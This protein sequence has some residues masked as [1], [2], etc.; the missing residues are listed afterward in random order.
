MTDQAPPTSDPLPPALDALCS[1]F[2]AA[3]QAGQRPRIEDCLAEA[4]PEHHPRLVRDLLAIEL[5]FRIRSGDRPTAE[6]LHARFPAFAAAVAAALSDAESVKTVGTDMHRRLTGPQELPQQLGRYRV[7]DQLGQGSFGIVYRARDDQLHRD[8]AI[9]VAHPERIT[10]EE[11]A[12]RYLVE[13]QNLA[14]LDHPG[15]VPVHD[16]G[17]TDDGR[18]FVVSKL[19]AGKDLAQRLRQGRPTVAESVE[20]VASVAEALHHAHRK[21]LV[22]RDI[23]PANI[24]LGADGHPVVADFGLALREA[25]FGTGPGFAGTPVYMSPEQARREGHRVDAR[26]DVYS[27]GVVFYEMLTGRRPFESNNRTEL[28]RLITM[29][30]PRPPRQHDDRI[31]QELDRICLKALSK[32]A[33]DR[34]STA[35]DLADDLRHWLRPL[36]AGGNLAVGGPRPAEQPHQLAPVA[37]PGLSKHVFISY[38]SPDQGAAHRLCQLLE[39]QGIGCWIAPRDV[40]PGADYGEAII[41]AIEE[42][43]ATVLL[44]SAHAN[45]SIHVTHEVERAT[46][47]RK[48]VVPVRLEDVRPSPSLELHL[49]SVQWVDAWRSAPHEVAAQLAAV[50]GG[51]GVARAIAPAAT[52]PL[53]PPGH[54]QRPVKIVPKGLRSF[55][56][57]DADFFLELVPGPRDRDGLPEGLRFW[58]GRIERMEADNTFAVGLMYGPS[59]CGKSSLVKAGLLPRLAKSVTAVYVEAT[60]EDTEARLFKGLRRQ[61]AELPCNLSLIESLAALRQGRFLKPG[62]KV[63]LVLDQFEQFLHARRNEENTELVQAL[64]Q[65]DGSRLQAIVLVRDDFWLAVSRFMQA[66]EIVPDGEN[67][68]LVDL[69]DPRHAKKVLIAFGQSFGALPEKDLAKDQAAFLDQAVAGLAQDGKVISVRLGLFAEMV[70]GKHWTPATLRKVGGTEGVGVSFLEETFTA[71]T[72]PPQHRLHQKAAQAV[73]KALLPEAGSDIKGHMR[74]Q[75]ELLMASGYVSRPKDFDDLLRILDS[76]VRLIT[77]TDPEG[78]DDADTSTLPA[79]GKYY[80]LT[81]D[82][83]V[84]SLR[85][86]LTRK[87]CETRRGRAELLLAERAAVWNAR[88]ENRQLPSLL[89]WLQIRALTGKKNWTPSERRMM[90]RAA[91]HHALR[92][93]AVFLVLGIIA[94]GSW[95]TYGTIQAQQFVN[96]LTNAKIAN[97]P[98]L[99]RSLGPYRRWADPLLLEQ[100]YW[101]PETDERLRISL[102]LLPIDPTQ[103]G[104]LQERL[105][106]A[107]EPEE[108]GAIR[109]L[110]HVYS[111]GSAEHFWAT[112]KSRQAKKGQRLRAAAAL[113]YLAPDDGQWPKWADTVVSCMALENM[114]YLQGWAAL[115]MPIEKHMNPH[116]IPQLVDANARAFDRYIAMLPR[117]EAT[118]AALQTKQDQQDKHATL[119]KRLKLA[120]QQ[121]HAAVALLFLRQLELVRPMFKQGDD[122]T[123]RTYFIHQCA[124]LGLEDSV[125]RSIL[126]PSSLFATSFLDVSTPLLALG[127][128][129]VEE[130]NWSDVVAINQIYISHPDP[131]VHSA[132]EWLMRRWGMAAVVS[133]SD[134]ILAT[135]HRDRDL[136]VIDKPRWCVNG[137]FQTFVVMPPLTRPHIGT[138]PN[139]VRPGR[140][141]ETD[142]REVQPAYPFA[143]AIKPVTVGDF[144]KH[145][146]AFMHPKIWSPGENT[147]INGV[148][149]YGAAAYCN[150]LSEQEGIPKEE[151][152]YEPNKSGIYAEGMKIKAGYLGLK[153]YR[154]PTEAEWEYACRAGTITE[155]PHGADVRLL[156]H[157]AWVADNSGMIMHDVGLLKPNGLG[158]FDMMGNARQWCQDVGDRNRN[159]EENEIVNTSKRVARGGSFLVASHLNLPA[160][161]HMLLPANPGVDQG[162]R[163]A[164]T[165]KS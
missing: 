142:S 161:R 96:N 97:V 163:V 85:E 67:S 60:G 129:E 81:H 43:V 87:Q 152:C 121:S 63:L 118:T 103:V 35:A 29:Q 111:P 5:Y 7:L 114:Q 72:A 62:E 162:F 26:T 84:P 9:K 30:E 66:L 2:E 131:G 64:R 32:R 13:A 113:A 65:C 110:L 73:L 90:R 55:D 51:E 61:V 53:P 46:S 95:W 116:I 147:P 159:A 70:K 137:Q 100:E 145:L 106:N 42:T 127:Q 89:Q 22:H 133:A 160:Y 108:V 68:R 146:P 92:A 80:Q 40:A 1:R 105:E 54:D 102:A 128:Y 123:C 69:F 94:L 101:P 20:I 49:A 109:E 117:T 139:S 140:E 38:A 28:L 150:W 77:P 122:P 15:I 130:I 25:D 57:T 6:Q 157:Y 119:D 56:A 76:E 10:S 71:S 45:A 135:T 52:P 138:G 11:E 132:A 4:P 27:L 31:P 17:R 78:K 75:Q 58:K 124:E 37:G 164:R 83:L 88:A 19:V 59:G 154:L 86:W 136:G 107:K 120:S 141:T 34:Y 12:E 112:L 14:G 74:T 126:A 153:G 47:K 98:D 93:T 155:W 104:F 79:G 156:K 134:K 23:K 125:L 144:K 21:G 143:V 82:Y 39:E 158:L 44:L 24:L 99:V 36:H 149:W 3:W 148:S 18:I 115:L 8:V 48:R 41:R 16:V 165:I 33:A 91:R 50:L 151:W